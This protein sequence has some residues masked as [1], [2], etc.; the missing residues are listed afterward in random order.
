MYRLGTSAIFLF[1]MA[2]LKKI[3][4]DSMDIVQNFFVCVFVLGHFK[5]EM[6]SVEGFSVF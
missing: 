2:N 3:I 5:E 1:K 6:V 4:E